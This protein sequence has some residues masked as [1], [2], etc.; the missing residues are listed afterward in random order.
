MWLRSTANSSQTDKKN[1]VNS[2]LSRPQQTHTLRYWFAKRVGGHGDGG[3][4]RVGVGDVWQAQHFVF[5]WFFTATA[6]QSPPPRRA[7]VLR[8]IASQWQ[9]TRQPNCVALDKRCFFLYSRL[10][11]ISGWFQQRGRGQMEVFYT[12][13][14]FFNFIRNFIA[15][16]GEIHL[17][18]QIWSPSGSHAAAAWWGNRK[19]WSPVCRVKRIYSAAQA[20]WEIYFCWV[21]DFIF[22]FRLMATLMVISPVFFFPPL[23]MVGAKYPAYMPSCVEFLLMLCGWSRCCCRTLVR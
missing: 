8:V 18:S 22:F 14:P 19:G 17:A 1:F 20:N 5:A 4:G 7:T 16:Q 9:E 6:H 23:Q 2:T 10:R 13:T 3:R 12:I 11:P 15:P 21:L